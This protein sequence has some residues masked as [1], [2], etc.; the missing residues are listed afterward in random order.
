[1]LRINIER[2]RRAA[3]P[4]IRRWGMTQEQP[5][6]ASLSPNKTGSK[7][8]GSMGT[9]IL[10][11]PQGGRAVNYV[12]TQSYGTM[13]YKGREADRVTNPIGALF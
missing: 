11:K 1:M 4:G 12:G 13:A 2:R 5:C 10:Q 3:N 9:H 8:G 6:A 7:E